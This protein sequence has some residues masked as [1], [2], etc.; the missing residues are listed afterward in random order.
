[1]GGWNKL[2][3][4]LFISMGKFD[5]RSALSYERSDGMNQTRQSKTPL[6]TA[7]AHLFLPLSANLSLFT[8]KMIRNIL[9]YI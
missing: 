6:H 1:M 3:A 9:Q 4:F 8:G 2:T 5:L 7:F